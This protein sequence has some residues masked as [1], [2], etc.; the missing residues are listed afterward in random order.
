MASTVVYVRAEKT[1]GP[2]YGYNLGTGQRVWT[3][4]APGTQAEDPLFAFNGGFVVL[5]G[6]R[7]HG[8]TFR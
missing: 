3:V 2:V 5:Q 7:G 4:P 1:D 6:L 8:L